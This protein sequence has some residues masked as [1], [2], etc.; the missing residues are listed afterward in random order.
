MNIPGAFRMG[1]HR[2]DTG[3]YS[4]E[5]GQS[6]DHAEA[7]CDQAMGEDEEEAGTT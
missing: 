3:V 7:I 2:A 4:C 1:V 6:G 5:C